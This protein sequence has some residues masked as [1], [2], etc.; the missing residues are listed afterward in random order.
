MDWNFVDAT[1]QRFRGEVHAN[2]GR[3]TSAHLDLIAGGRARLASKI[4]E[5]Y[6]VTGDEAERQIKSSEARNQQPHPASVERT[7]VG[8]HASTQSRAQSEG[9][10]DGDMPRVLI[11]D[12]DADAAD[13]S[14]DARASAAST[15]SST[16]NT[17]GNRRGTV[18]RASRI[19]ARLLLL[20]LSSSC[21]RSCSWISICR[22]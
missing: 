14:N 7:V 5:A 11:V 22:T 20:S 15:S 17:R 10:A 9:G 4:K 13:C 8:A 12:D 18:M 3:L 1:W 6:G 19:P 21:P 2:W 16:I